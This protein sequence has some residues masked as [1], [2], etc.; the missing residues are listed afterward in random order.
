VSAAE[1]KAALQAM[2]WAA[3]KGQA[4]KDDLPSEKQT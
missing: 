3:I 1:A 2:F 4:G